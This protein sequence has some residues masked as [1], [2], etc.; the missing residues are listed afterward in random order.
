MN[1]L[2]QDDEV[3]QL[4][5][6][7]S[8]EALQRVEQ[9]LLDAEEGRRRPD[10]L[11]VMFRDMHTIKGTAALLAYEKTTSLAHAAED[12][13]SALRDKTMQAQP[14]HF[15]IMVKVVDS[16]RKYVESV[17]DQNTEGTLD[18][19]E[20]ID[21]LK[22]FTETGD[23]DLEPAA[24][25]APPAPAS[26]PS[27]PQPAPPVTLFAPLQ[28]APPPAAVA[29]PVA[30]QDQPPST[31]PQPAAPAPSA[32]EH[33]AAHHGD[34]DGTVRVNVGVLDKLMNLMGELVLSRNQMVQLLRGQ[35]DAAAQS[36]A[37]RLSLVTSDLQQQIMKT[38][39]QP[40]ARV[41]EKIPRQVR[42]LAQQ[43][44]K[45]VSVEI[46]GTTTE[47]DKALVEAIRD[48]LMHIIR[49]AID[50]GIE[51]PAERQAR[52]KS[53]TGNL[54][55][56]AVH[57][58]NNVS[59]EVR[60]DGKGIDPTIVKRVA[61]NRGVITQAEADHLTERE[62]VELIFRPGFSTAEKVTSISGRGV[63]MDV[64]R[65]HVERAGGAVELESELGKGATIR[66]KMPL[67]LAI[68]PALLVED[69]GQ[70]FAVPQA[71]L[72]E[73]VRLNAE[74]AK[75]QI[76]LVR[77]A[78][79]YRLRGEILPVVRLAPLLRRPAK[80][81]GAVNLVV[82]QVG[83]RR[84]GL[85][86]ESIH[87][88]E[89]IVIK[90]LHRL[91]KKLGCYAGA[92]VLGDGGM[93]LILD[94]SGVAAMAGIDLSGRTD[95]HAKVEQARSTS[96]T[97]LVFQSGE[98]R[99]GVPV[100]MVARLEQ[101]PRSELEMVAGAEV[102]QYRGEIMPIVRP[103]GAMPL[104]ASPPN[105]TG[106]QQLL[107]FN[108]GKPVGLAVDV[109]LDATEVASTHPC[110]VPHTLGRA[111]VFGKTTLILDVFS[112]VRQ[113]APATLSDVSKAVR[114]PRVLLAAG[115]EA[116]RASIAAWLRAS[117]VEVVEASTEGA[118]KELRAHQRPFDAV[119]AGLDPLRRGLE[120][121]RTLRAELP[122]LPV[123]CLSREDLSAQATAVGA[124]ACVRHV[125]REALLAALTD[126]G[127]FTSPEVTAEAA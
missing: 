48:P 24:V 41:F 85:A 71:N 33:K 63:G 88:T 68:I 75:T 20:M 87:D 13:M 109:I 35:R 122:E 31:P 127:L 46:D 44:N 56:R 100:S 34:G 59:I 81:S 16:L 86:V 95:H 77:G 61:V 7:E 112:L 54:L 79:V 2:S 108:F 83:Q 117:G 72:L 102:L 118:L 98:A 92:T 23:A 123:V 8:M 110:D 9:I 90:P 19:S 15:A 36:A 32:P 94:V 107:V 89:E 58:G 28:S 115:L 114:K 29:P 67:T 120:L 60:D 91:L 53:P 82:V 103:E 10:M 57:E 21:E 22:Y 70:R 64:V 121:V 74:Q 5:V 17:R 55:V 93:A 47:L 50:H 45:K 119:I 52:G 80:E 51:S 42:D 116:L 26:A 66:L 124:R 39:M 49:N 111:V 38:R 14:K 18:S 101:V 12:L 37:Q 125:E 69:G 3:K 62:A 4:F 106:M 40:I 76:E 126:A 104:G 84:Y 11:D 97:M 25:A 113:L 1:D 65:T 30:A 73:L 6:D 99:C 27:A 105:E 43:T 78:P 96:Q